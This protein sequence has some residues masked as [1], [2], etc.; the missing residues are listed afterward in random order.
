MLES[1]DGERPSG[2]ESIE[3]LPVTGFRFID[4]VYH[5]VY[6]LDMINPEAATVPCPSCAGRF[7][8]VL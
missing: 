7:L 2:P 1:V 8:I 6:T 3:P 5:F 4:A